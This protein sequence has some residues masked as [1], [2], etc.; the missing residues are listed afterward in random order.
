MRM[1]GWRRVDDGWTTRTNRIF[2]YTTRK[3]DSVDIAFYLQEG[4]ELGARI[5]YPVLNVVGIKNDRINRNDILMSI[6][7]RNSWQAKELVDCMMMLAVQLQT[8]GISEEDVKKWVNVQL[9]LM[10]TGI[11]HRDREPAESINATHNR[12]YSR[13]F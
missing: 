7:C 6:N 10:D 11:S 12:R 8:N 1:V 4:N 3:R 13:T 9:K 5:K 2:N